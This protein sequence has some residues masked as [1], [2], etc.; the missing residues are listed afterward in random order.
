MIQVEATTRLSV[1]LFQFTFQGYRLHDC[2]KKRSSEQNNHK[3][4]KLYVAPD[5]SIVVYQHPF[6][7][8]ASL[9]KTN[10]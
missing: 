5:I 9:T 4:N 8:G 2:V 10:V 6:S 7:L 1:K 3:S